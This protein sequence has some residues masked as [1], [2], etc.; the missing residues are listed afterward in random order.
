M[1]D[2]PELSPVFWG[3]KLLGIRVGLSRTVPGFLGGQTAWNF[4]GIGPE[5]DTCF[6]GTLLDMSGELL[7]HVPL[8]WGGEAASNLNWILYNCIFVVGAGA[9]AHSGAIFAL[10][11]VGAVAAVHDKFGFPAL[12]GVAGRCYDI[13]GTAQISPPSEGHL[14]FWGDALLGIRVGLIVQNCT[15]VSGTNSC[16]KYSI[17]VFYSRKKNGE[18]RKKLHQ[19]FGRQTTRNKRCFF[20]LR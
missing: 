11:T 3:D 6:G 9:A 19:R 15:D 16:L 2:C 20:F 18:L 12:F 10:A 17:L 7:R 4:C 8:L 5:L 1:E 13:P 14:S